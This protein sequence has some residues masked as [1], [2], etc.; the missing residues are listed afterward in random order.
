MDAHRRFGLRCTVL[1]LG[2]IGASTQG[3]YCNHADLMAAWITGVHAVGAQPHSTADPAGRPIHVLPV[4]SCAAALAEITLLRHSTVG[5]GA[6]TTEPGWKLLHIAGAASEGAHLRL[7]T[8]LAS[9]SPSGLTRCTEEV[10]AAKL[11]TASSA[12]CEDLRSAPSAWRTIA[13]S[14]SGL[15]VPRTGPCDDAAARLYLLRCSTA[16]DGVLLRGPGGSRPAADDP[17]Y[18]DAW[19]ASVLRHGTRSAAVHR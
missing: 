11:D 2:L 16:G 5:S 14:R 18:W 12:P 1:R 3:G 19:V 15:A 10:F 6:G 13:A 8:A 9:A 17:A 7:A 4:D